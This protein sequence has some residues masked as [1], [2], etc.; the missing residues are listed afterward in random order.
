MEK[1]EKY[2]FLQWRDSL[3]SKQ[4]ASN[5]LQ[6]KAWNTAEG[7]VKVFMSTSLWKQ[8]VP[9]FGKLFKTVKYKIGSGVKK[10]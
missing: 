3:K 9:T 2:M 4:T 5:N 10:E 8:S 7:S 6:E 1:K